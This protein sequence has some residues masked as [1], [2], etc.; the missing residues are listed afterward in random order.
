MLRILLCDDDRDE[1][2]DIS[3]RL[4]AYFGGQKQALYG[5]DDPH[6]ALEFAGSHPVDVA[7]LDILM[8]GMTGIELAEKLRALGYAGYLVFLTTVN[9]YA[10]QS[11]RVGAFD[12]LIKPVSAQTVRTLMDRLVEDREKS[13][14]EGFAVKVKTEMLQIRYKELMYAEVIGNNLYF[15]LDKGRTIKAYAA[16]KEYAGTLLGDRRM[17]RANKS[18]IVNMDYIVDFDKHAVVMQ[19]GAR[20]SITG[21]VKDFKNTCNRHMFGGDRP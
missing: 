21:S 11:Y 15:H 14:S 16:L 5:F 9:D 2:A 10:A 17:L 3:A 1:L 12:Y 18:F 19:G 4:E 6:N 20:V 8:P 13:D 7:V